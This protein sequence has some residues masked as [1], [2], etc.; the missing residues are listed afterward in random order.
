MIGRNTN[1][2]DDSDGDS[3]TLDF[4]YKQLVYKQLHPIL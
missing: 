1:N 3:D 2:N 4:F